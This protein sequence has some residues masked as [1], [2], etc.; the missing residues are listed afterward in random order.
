VIASY[1]VLAATGL[2]T[3][4]HLGLPVQAYDPEAYY[5][6]VESA[7]VARSEQGRA[8]DRVLQAIGQ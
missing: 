5:N 3:A 7:P 4:E 6:L 8:L 1:G 2:L